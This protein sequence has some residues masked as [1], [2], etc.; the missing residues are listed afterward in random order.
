MNQR[1]STGKPVRGVQNQL[2]EVK[3]DLNNLKVSDN[4]YNQK[5]YTN[6]R[7]KLNRSESVQTLDQRGQCI[8]MVFFLSQQR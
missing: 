2:T 4:R 3:L 5:V 1:R 7:Q 6:V 8:D